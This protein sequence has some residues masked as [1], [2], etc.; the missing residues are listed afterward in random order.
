MSPS[1]RV[2]IDPQDWTFDFNRSAGTPMPASV[3][4]TWEAKGIFTDTYTPLKVEDPT[5]EYPTTLAQGLPNTTHTLEL[6][7]ADGKPL[8]IS[9]IRVYQ[10]PFKDVKPLHGQPRDY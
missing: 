9:F 8:D 5:R 4:V 2:I 3:T 1:G 6:V 7:S 10:P